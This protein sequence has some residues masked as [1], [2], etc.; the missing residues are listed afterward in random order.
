[1]TNANRT[2]MKTASMKSIKRGNKTVV[3]H[4]RSKPYSAGTEMGFIT[5]THFLHSKP[6]K[7]TYAVALKTTQSDRML[8]RQEVANRLN[9]HSA[10]V[11]KLVK[12]GIFKTVEMLSGGNYLIS[13]K[14][15][16]LLQKKMQ[17]SRRKH[18]D[19]MISV[20]SDIRKKEL[21]TA[22]TKAKRNWIK[23]AA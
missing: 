10:Y 6:S 13:A 22:R 1:M 23:V 9:V 20:T 8:S 15:V 18:L 17:S 3:E 16:D 7:P 19:R 14:E 11:S 12:D 2:I 4:V 21:D 5:V